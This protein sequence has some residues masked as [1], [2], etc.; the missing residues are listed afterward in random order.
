MQYIKGFPIPDPAPSP[1]SPVVWP[2]G[3]TCSSRRSLAGAPIPNDGRPFLHR[4]GTS[5]SCAAKLPS[6]AAPHH[7]VGHLLTAHAN[8]ASAPPTSSFSHRF[9]WI[10]RCRGLP[11]EF[12]VVA[13]FSARFVVPLAES[14]SSQLD[15]SLSWPSRPDQPL[16]LLFCRGRGHPHFMMKILRFR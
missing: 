15:P 3:R 11:S 10:R 9:R 1:S 7:R 6:R 8:A 16:S 12:T 14:P 13:T 2:R 5:P 4:R